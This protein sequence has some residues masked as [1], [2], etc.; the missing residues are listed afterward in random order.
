[1]YLNAYG[2]VNINGWDGQG[3]DMN[4]EEGSIFANMIGAGYKRPS[5]NAFTGVLIGADSSNPRLRP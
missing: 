1:M 5:T 2:N 4:E 3:I